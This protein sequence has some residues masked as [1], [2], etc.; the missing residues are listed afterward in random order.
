MTALRR[1]AFVVDEFVGEQDAAFDA[2]EAPVEN[3]DDLVA[4]A[5]Q[6]AA[7]GL[8]GEA[9][10]ADG[11]VGELGGGTPR[12]PSVHSPTLPTGCDELRPGDYDGCH[13]ELAVAA[14]FG[15]HGMFS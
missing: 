3:V 14:R 10:E 11:E 4:F 2:G 12:R 6:N 5:G 9:G 13:L 8:I 1:S 15:C 7:A